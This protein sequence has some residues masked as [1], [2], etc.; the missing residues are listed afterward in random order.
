MSTDQVRTQPAE[1]DAWRRARWLDIAGTRGKAKVVGNGQ[2][3]GRD[4]RVIEGVPG[5]WS[6]NEAGALTVTAAARDGVMVDGA[7]VEGTVVLVDGSRLEFPGGRRGFASGS[8]GSYSVV[9][10]DDAAL[11]DSGIT[12]ID[13][14]PH[15]PDWVVEG[16]YRK[17]PEGRRIEVERLSNP[18][19]VHQIPSPVDLAVTIAGTEYVL[20]VLEDSP[21]R[22]LVVFTDETNGAGTPD[23]GR[24]LVLPLLASDGALTVD[25]NKTT[26]SYHHVRP[27]IFHC[28]LSP[29]G[30]HLPMRIEVGER[31][32]RYDE[33]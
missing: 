19:S 11:A 9:V 20:A 29:P 30:N 25:F 33:S 21:G 24:W 32:Y 3:V 17:A 31:A 23:I 22:R 28:P 13:T 6:T 2:V 15:D 27:A 1:Y 7:T 18:L 12:G 4:P 5:W 16:R 8:D 26:L 14:Y 10:F